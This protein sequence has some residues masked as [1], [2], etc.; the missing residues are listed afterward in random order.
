[1]RTRVGWAEGAFEG[2]FAG[3]VATWLM[4]KATTLM[5]QKESQQARREED[6][7]RGGKTAYGIAAEKVAQAAG[8]TLSEPQR[9]RAGTG[10]HWLLGIGTAAAYGAVRQLWPRAAAGRGL[11]FGAAVWLVTDE[12]AV[13]ALGLTP[14]PQDFPWQTHARALAGHLVFG[15]ATEAALRGIA[16][17]A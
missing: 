2:A 8:T 15:G 1:M 5:Y 7:A 17:V 10:L 11:L 12:I 13:T 4:S 3:A 14:P 9:Q 6:A 16:V